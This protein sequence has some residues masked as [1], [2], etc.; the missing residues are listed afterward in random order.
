MDKTNNALDISKILAL[1][2]AIMLVFADYS[3]AKKRGG[4]SFLRD[5]E[6]EHTIRHMS[7]PIFIA[8]NLDPNSVSSYL[9]NDNSLNAFVAGGQNVF[10]H[11]GLLLAADDANQV[12]GVIAH[13]T[14]HIT[15]GHLTRFSEGI[16]SATMSTLIGAILGAA[17]I[18]AGAG[19][20]GMALILGGQQVGMRTM[21]KYTRTQESSTDQAALTFLNKSKQSG[22]GLLEFF[23]HMGDQEL[24]SSRYRDPYARTHPL[25]ND[26]IS[27]LREGV[28]KS[29]YYYARTSET[30]EHE[31]QRLKAKLYGYLKPAYATLNKYPEKDQ[32]IYARYA[33][34]FAYNKKHDFDK[35]LSEINSLLADSPNDPYFWE[36][37][38]QILFEN[39]KIKQSILPYQNA[40]KNL[41]DEALIRVSLA[42]SMLATEEDSYL[43]AAMR[44]L[45]Y[46][47]SRDPQNAFA[48]RQASVAYH[49]SHNDAMTRYASAERFLLIGNLG[50]AMFN[51]GKAVGLLPKK[52]PQWYRAQD[53]LMITRANM[54]DRDRKREKERNKQQKKRERSQ[55]HGVLQ[56]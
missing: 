3:H 53:I 54:S 2:L 46:A 16:K 25:S 27:K 4:M 49:R 36:T 26:R 8:A 45:E 15:G 35:A 31:F 43:P 38:G 23:Y 51:A 34:T 44:H 11:T 55:R 42:Q 47:L 5:S 21:L 29:P 40:V 33:R 37:K 13:E 24:I 41:P 9:I 6:I 14:G 7:E 17:A 22:K 12:I 56:Y 10:L 39:G 30:L 1:S 48:W 50:A 19:D 52:S 20:A 18:A 32:S 28:E